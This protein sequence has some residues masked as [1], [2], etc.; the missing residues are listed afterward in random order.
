MIAGPAYRAAADP[1]S[2]KIP[3]PMMAPIPSV[4][5]LIG[6]NARLRLCSPVSAAS[7]IK[8]SSGFVANKGLPMQL[9]LCEDR[10]P[11]TFRCQIGLAYCRVVRS[12]ALQQTFYSFTFIFAFCRDHSQYTGSPNNTITRLQPAVSV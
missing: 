6:P 11:G 9:L 12:F 3:A 4:T 2:T 7:L 1:V 5:R 10:L 8:L